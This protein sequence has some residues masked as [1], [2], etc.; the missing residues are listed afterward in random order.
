MAH[1]IRTRVHC[2]G[3]PAPEAGVGVGV[4]IE[5]LALLPGALGDCGQKLLNSPLLCCR[6]WLA[7]LSV[8]LGANR[9]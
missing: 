3:V 8:H 4:R 6:C 2:A 7:S 5:E 9:F 1:G